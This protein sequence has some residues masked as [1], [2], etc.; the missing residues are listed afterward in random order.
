MSG[1]P[2]IATEFRHGAVD[3]SSVRHLSIT[4]DRSSSIVGPNPEIAKKKLTCSGHAT[5][6]LGGG[7]TDTRLRR[8]AA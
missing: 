4:A 7:A 5:N 6:S 8:R 3:R 2:P 1:L